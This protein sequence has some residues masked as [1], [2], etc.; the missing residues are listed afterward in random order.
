MWLVHRVR[1]QPPKC[2]LPRLRVVGRIFLNIQPVQ[3]G[4][5]CAHIP[6]AAMARKWFSV[7]HA[8][9]VWALSCSTDLFMLRP[10]LLARDLSRCAVL[11][12]GPSAEQFDQA[13]YDAA[14]ISRAWR[15]RACQRHIAH[16]IAPKRLSSQAERTLPAGDGMATHPGPVRA[17]PPY[18]ISPPTGTG[19][20]A[21]KFL[22]V[23][24]V[25]AHLPPSI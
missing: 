24:T 13:P 1:E 18:G 12:G 2:D 25:P 22:S 21:A 7:S 15:H 23:A 19:S 4:Q 9:S 5:G 14:G 20:A 17:L 8:D 16:C 3:H 10:R 11:G 6:V